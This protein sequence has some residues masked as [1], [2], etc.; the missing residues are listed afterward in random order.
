[1]TNSGITFLTA[2]ATLTGTAGS[3]GGGGGGEQAASKIAGR[4]AIAA[5]RRIERSRVRTNMFS[6]MN[7]GATRMLLERQGDSWIASAHYR[8]TVLAAA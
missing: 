4:T 3:A 6:L 7:Q 2:V 1:V 5:D 8:R